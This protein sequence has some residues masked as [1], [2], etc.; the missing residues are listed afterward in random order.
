MF[1]CV[2]C[3]V[4]GCRR[5]AMED[6]YTCLRHASDSE[7]VLQALIASLTDSHRHRDIMLTD[8]RLKGIDFSNVHLTTC[9]FARCV[10]EDVDFSNARVQA[11]FFD[12]CLFENCSF[13]GCDARHSVIAGSKLIRSSFTDSLLIHTNFMGIDARDCDFSSSDLYYSNF[14]SSHLV[15][16]QFIDCNLK[17]ADFRFTDREQVS[18]KYSNYEEASFS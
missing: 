12:F 2:P 15:N 3:A 1:K 11:C 8:V 4:E 10:F 14:S 16:V 18:F 5:Y 7:K 6:M 9:D 17:N 13:K